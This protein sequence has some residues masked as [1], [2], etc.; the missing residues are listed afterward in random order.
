MASAQSAQSAQIEMATKDKQEL[1]QESP[2]APKPKG[3]GSM[4]LFLA[5]FFLIYKASDEQIFRLAKSLG[6][7]T[8]SSVSQGQRPSKPNPQGVSKVQVENSR[9]EHARRTKQNFNRI[10]DEVNDKLTQLFITTFALARSIVPDIR[11]FI[12]TD[13]NGNTFFVV[14]TKKGVRLFQKSDRIFWNK[15]SKGFALVRIVITKSGEMVLE[16]ILW[17]YICNKSLDSF[18]LGKSEL[19]FTVKEGFP[20]NSALLSEW[21][22][23]FHPVETQEVE[24]QEVVSDD[25]DPTPQ[26]KKE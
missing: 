25:E 10:C 22:T 24:N 11:Q 18:P 5:L 21:N 12:L 2:H 13:A 23:F 14:E 9:N 7:E 26:G 17:S 15:T 20:S 19:S 1:K 4:S 8:T 6:I 16:Q 3:F